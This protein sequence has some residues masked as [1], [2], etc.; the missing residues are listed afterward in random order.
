M[1]DVDLNIDEIF[2]QAVGGEIKWLIEND[3]L[4]RSQRTIAKDLGFTNTTLINM[5]LGRFLPDMMQ[6]RKLTKFFGLSA[7]YFQDI[8]DK[9]IAA[10]YA[11]LEAETLTPQGMTEHRMPK[12]VD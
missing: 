11:K 1:T 2:K 10:A 5:K 4:R 3:P 7:D 6:E 9:A 8:G 12:G